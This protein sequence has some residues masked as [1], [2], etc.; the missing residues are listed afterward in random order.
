MIAVLGPLQTGGPP[1]S[2]RER[3]ALGV[4]ALRAPDPV[5]ADEIADALWGENP[6]QTWPKQVQVCISR[7]R[8]KLPPGTVETLGR[9]YRLTADGPDDLDVRAFEIRV[10]QARDFMTRGEPDRAV[11]AFGRALALWRGPAYADVADWPGGEGE[12]GRLSAL[13]LMV[14]EEWLEA[15]L[16][17]GE[18]TAAAVDARAM[19]AREPLR[20]RRWALLALAHYRCGRQGEALA[21]LR[22]AR[23]ALAVE[24]GVDPGE[25]LVALEQ[26]ILRHAERLTPPVPQVTASTVCPYRGLTPFGPGDHETFFGRRLEVEHCMTRLRSTRC[27]VITGASGSGKTSM[28]RAG[29]MAA[30][31]RAGAHPRY[32]VPGTDP[33]GALFAVLATV[34]DEEPL[35]VD[36][37]EELFLLGHPGAVVGEFCRQLLLES[38]QRPLVLAIRVDQLGELGAQPGMGE[39]VEL[40]LHLVRPFDE[41]QLRQVIEGPA[42]AA[43]LRLEPGLVD[44]LLRD[45]SEGQGALPLLSH[46]LVEVWKQRDG[47]VLTVAGYRAAGGLAG[48]VARTADELYDRL[49]EAEQAA[50]RSVMLHLVELSD[51][52]APICRRMPRRALIGNPSQERVVRDLVQARLLTLQEET[53]EVSHEALVRAWPRLRSWLE[54]DA[55]AVRTL[56]HLTLAAQGWDALGR[57][58]SELYRGTRLRLALEQTRDAAADLTVLDREFL[59]AAHEQDRSDLEAAEERA[60]RERRSNRRLRVL[61]G[62]TA[63][64]LVLS[65]LAGTFAVANRNQA[66]AQRSSAQLEALVGRSLALRATDRDTAALLA[67]EAYR[68]F[69]GEAQARSALLATFTAD[70]GFLGYRSVSGAQRLDGTVLADGSTALVVMDG[71]RLATMN[72]ETGQLA[73]LEIDVGKPGVVADAV[74]R[75]SLDGTVVAVLSGGVLTVDRLD[76]SARLLGPLSVPKGGALAL[77]PDGALVATSERPGAV[78]V[79]RVSDATVLGRLPALDEDPNG[80]AGLGFTTTGTLVVG[81]RS[82]LVRVVETT[83]LTVRAQVQLPQDAADLHIVPVSDTL[84]VTAGSRRLAAFDPSTGEV[85]WRVDLRSSG[86]EPCRNVVVAG[87]AER[88]YCGDLFGVIQERDLTTG[89]LTGR[90]FDVQRNDVGDLALADAERELVAFGA[91]DPVISRWRLDGSGPVTTLIAEGHVTMDGFEPQGQLFVAAKRPPGAVWFDEM[92][93]FAIWDATADRAV[94]RFPTPMEGMGWIAPEEVVGLYLPSKELHVFDARSGRLV[95]TEP[96]P[97]GNE[98]IWPGTARGVSYYTFADGRV[99]TIDAETKARTEP[100]FT[101]GGPVNVLTTSPD[102]TLIAVIAVVDGTGELTVHD[103]ATGER[104]GGPVLGVERV[105][106][107]EHAVAGARGGSVTV[108]DPT[109]LEPRH[110]LPGARGEVNLLAFD[111]EGSTLLATSHDQTVSVYDTSAWI[112]LGDP[113]AADAPIIYPAYLH[114]SGDSLLVTVAEGVARW[115]LDGE[116]LRAAACRV[117]GRDLTTTEWTAYLDQLGPYRPTCSR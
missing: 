23:Q 31:E 15:R 101:V 43:G 109:T 10:G 32:L 51:D 63:G 97:V 67:V 77:S 35:V 71:Q 80:A 100:S 6:P 72:P 49:S 13:R 90:R 54:E 116:T 55:D 3:A 92:T 110:D 117:A 70:P 22:R 65:F 34:R 83:D 18:H 19:V 76:R 20:E 105:A 29:I 94:A 106:V 25:E 57:P 16:A 48:A 98:N 79:R 81:S 111:A 9:G 69:P 52:G 50:C 2:P 108:Y 114:P 115:R 30:L 40:A 96:L 38:R 87:Q 59:A 60:A 113:I 82:G 58:P 66:V 5:A 68:R 8:A 56:R 17:V 95:R 62:S 107:S 37:L 104:V 78:T 14:E 99:W 44:L 45:A 33:L 53:V 4:L 41:D 64:L 12:R 84:V 74:V 89:G 1:L 7:M 46:L 27:L 61:L 85:R 73:P 36:Q 103:A 42:T 102:G 21:T 24:L 47:P 39:L 93:E 75:T 26:D 86:L 91:F 28:L 88:L 112:R 11:T